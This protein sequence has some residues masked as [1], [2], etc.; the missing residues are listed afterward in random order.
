MSQITK[1]NIIFEDSNILVIDKPSGITV[2][3]S[4]TQ[5]DTTIQDM[6]MEHF[7]CEGDPGSE[8]VRRY[9]IVHRLDKDTSG[10]LIVSKTQPAFENLQLQFK[11]RNTHK[12]YNAVVLGALKDTRVEIDAPIK[13]DPRNRTKMCIMPNGR[14]SLTRV[15]VQNI[16]SVEDVE[17]SFLKVLPVTG[18]THQIRVHMSAIGA[19]VLHDEIYMTRYQLNMSK[20][21]VDRLMLHAL[22]LEITHPISGKKEVFSSKLPDIF[23]TFK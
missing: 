12:V 20:T 8:F 21:V 10:V 3:K 2:N 1:L 7:E 6:L 19:P 16:G 18:R 14:E 13:R 11:N 17:C 15:E 9:G 22:S 4:N 5:K 23:T